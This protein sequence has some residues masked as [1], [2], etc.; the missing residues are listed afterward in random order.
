M[1][2]FLT[3]ALLASVA[4]PLASAARAADY[5]YPYE[6]GPPRAYERQLDERPVIEEPPVI[7]ERPVYRPS[8]RPIVRYYPRPF[9]GQ[10]FYDGGY[11]PYRRHRYGYAHRYGPYGYAPY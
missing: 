11:G 9:Y 2:R 4:L 6:Q 3:T 1:R 8:Y 7:E 5:D 10:P